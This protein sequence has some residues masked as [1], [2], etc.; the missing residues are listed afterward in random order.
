MSSTMEPLGVDGFVESTTPA[1]E[2]T[3]HAR[4]RC[5]RAQGISWSVHE[6][7]GCYIGPSLIFES[8]RIVRRV[9]AFPRDWEHLSDDE[10]VALSWSR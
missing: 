2:T 6:D 8:D 3:G 4:L 9:R 10:L 5:F 1:L 7:H